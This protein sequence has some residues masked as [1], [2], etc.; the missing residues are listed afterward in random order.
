MPQLIDVNKSNENGPELKIVQ[1][2]S[3][4]INRVEENNRST[5]PKTKQKKLRKTTIATHYQQ[6]QRPDTPTVCQPT[7]YCPNVGESENIKQHID[8][9]SDSAKKE[10]TKI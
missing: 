4:P 1:N 3:C 9:P 5:Q 8:K 6:P 10:T 2:K 7:K